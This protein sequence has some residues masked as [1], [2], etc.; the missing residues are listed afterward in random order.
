MFMPGR[1]EG[2][3]QNQGAHG[4]IFIP[5]ELASGGRG[6]QATY[7]LLGHTACRSVAVLPYQISIFMTKL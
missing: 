3:F 6:I 1:Y 5:E 7:G 2:K 4:N